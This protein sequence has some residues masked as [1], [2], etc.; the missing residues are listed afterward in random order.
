V[1]FL[2]FNLQLTCVSVKLESVAD[3][4]RIGCE[5]RVSCCKFILSTDDVSI[6]FL[7]QSIVQL[8]QRTIGFACGGAIIG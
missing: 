3:T 1:G 2:L 7:A 6:G 5:L 4:K 8:V